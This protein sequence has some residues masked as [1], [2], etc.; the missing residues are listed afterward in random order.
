[1]EG[2]RRGWVSGGSCGFWGC[3][4]GL[5]E[6]WRGVVCGPWRAFV[7]CRRR[8]GGCCQRVVGGC[9]CEGGG[10]WGVFG[11]RRSWWGEGCRRCGRSAEPRCGPRGLRGFWTA[12][13]PCTRSREG[14]AFQGC[15]RQCLWC[16]TFAAGSAAALCL[17]VSGWVLGDGMD[18]GCANSIGAVCSAAVGGGGD[19][20]GALG[21]TRGALP[22][23]R[24]SSSTTRSRNSSTW[25]SW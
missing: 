5:E 2:C 8:G 16:G 12:G 1:L 19:T 11:G 3:R 21:S 17:R 13:G 18:G 4:R 9:R 25:S 22:S 10:R 14:W 23:R 15:G 24:V 7:A 6:C 20:G